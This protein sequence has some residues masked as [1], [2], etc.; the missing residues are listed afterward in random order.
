MKKLLINAFDPQKPVFEVDFSKRTFR[1]VAL[2][3]MRGGRNLPD[4]CGKLRK[5]T[6]FKGENFFEVRA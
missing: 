1:L 2:H 5:A 4:L 3:G 6:D